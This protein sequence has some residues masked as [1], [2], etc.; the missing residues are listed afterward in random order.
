VKKILLSLVTL[1]AF[2]LWGVHRQWQKA[3][4]AIHLKPA[5]ATIWARLYGFD[6]KLN[7]QVVDIPGFMVPLDMV[8]DTV[9][10]FILIPNPLGCL[11]VPPPAPNQ[12]VRVKMLR[13]Q[14]I[15]FRSDP[16]VVSG[17]LLVEGSSKKMRDDGIYALEASQV[18][19][20]SP[21]A[22]R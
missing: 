5:D 13:S 14:K 7:K 8:A 10:E 11:H 3:A 22:A 12:I 4:E 6:P 21:E 9:S 1:G 18:V 16:V 19:E 15:S 2:L 17:L 20:M